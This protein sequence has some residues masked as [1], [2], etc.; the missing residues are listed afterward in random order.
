MIVWEGQLRCLQNSICARFSPV[1]GVWQANA[2]SRADLFGTEQLEHH[3]QTLAAAQLISTDKPLRVQL[4]SHRVR[5]NAD[6][7]SVSVRCGPLV[8][9]LDGLKLQGSSSSRR[10]CG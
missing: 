5:E 6:G 7:C 10:F 9:Y 2:P 4:L 1:P 3:A 8:A